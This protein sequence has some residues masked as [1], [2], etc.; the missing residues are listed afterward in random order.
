LRWDAD[1]ERVLNRF[2]EG[3]RA[4]LGD[5]VKRLRAFGS[6]VMGTARPSSDLD[7]LVLLDKVDVASYREVC[8]VAYDASAADG[9]AV[10]LSARIMSVEEF[11]SMLSRER[12][13][14]LDIERFGV[15]IA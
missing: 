3:L 2:Q 15:E 12:R 1:E 8:N 6:R 13:L 7:V 4:S 10:D 14:A 9:F 5:R 11:E